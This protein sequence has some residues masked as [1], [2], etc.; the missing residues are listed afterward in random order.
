MMRI[1]PILAAAAAAALAIAPAIALTPAASASA[2]V[3]C[4]GTTLIPG[5]GGGQVR[6]PT[7][8]DGSGK[9][10]CDLGLNNSGEAVSRLQI[11]L[12]Y[13]NLHATLAVDGDYG[14][15]TEQAVRAFQDTSK[16]LAH[17]GVFGPDTSGAMKWPVAGSNNTKCEWWG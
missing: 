3:S 5:V 9:L 6:V 10:N 17:D 7:T 1:R 11:A 15:K 2:D 14:P 13:C 8:T 12:D 4:A 16:G